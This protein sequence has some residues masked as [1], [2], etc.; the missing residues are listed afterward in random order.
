MPESK[1]TES[2]RFRE[3][4]AASAGGEGT[5]LYGLTGDGRVYQWRADQK[6]WI[7]LPMLTPAAEDSN[8]GFRMMTADEMQ[9]G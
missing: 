7:S 3:I 6:L 8:T 2:I 9:M 4:A 1:E 5:I